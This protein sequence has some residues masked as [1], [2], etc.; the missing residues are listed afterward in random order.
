MTLAFS[1]SAVSF[2]LL[3]MASTV[4]LC[5][6]SIPPPSTSPSFVCVFKS[7]IRLI[8][9]CTTALTNLEKQKIF[10]EGVEGLGFQDPQTQVNPKSTTYLHS[11]HN[12]NKC[13]YRVDL[14][15]MSRFGA[16]ILYVPC[17][18]QHPLCSPLFKLFPTGYHT[19]TTQRILKELRA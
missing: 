11:I 5:A 8:T 12:I 17:H 6:V 10:Q 1:L 3:F 9:P 16:L 13:H 18:F 4:A 2:S 19:L 7:L 15:G 14:D